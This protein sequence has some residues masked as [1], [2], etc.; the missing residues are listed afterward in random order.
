MNGKRVSKIVGPGA[1]ASPGFKP[2]RRS[3]SRKVLDAVFLLARRGD[4]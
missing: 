3:S 2:A 1:H 4:L